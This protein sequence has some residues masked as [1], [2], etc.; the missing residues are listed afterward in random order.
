MCFVERRG[1]AQVASDVAKSG[2]KGPCASCDVLLL[3]D[4]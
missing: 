3:M 1:I 2:G 4:L